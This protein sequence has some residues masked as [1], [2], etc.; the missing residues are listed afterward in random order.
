[1]TKKEYKIGNKYSTRELM[2]LAVLL[3]YESIPEHADR[4][5][6][7]VGAV[8]AKEDGTLI[9]KAYR[10]EL[11]QGDHAEFTVLERKHRT[12]KLD[13]FIIYS[14][15]EPCAPGARSIT[16]LS[17]A[18][19]IVNARIKKVFIG[20]EDPD[21]KV[22]GNGIA[23]LNNNHIEIDFFDKDLQEKTLIANEPFLK[24]AAD[25]A[26]TAEQ[27]ELEPAFTELDKILENF[28]VKDFS[29][30]AL[31]KFREKLQISYPIESMDFKSI[32]RK[33][34]FIRVE[35]KNKT[36]YPTGLGILLFGKTPQVP[37]PQSLVKFTIKT[38]NENKPKIL[39]FDGPLVLIPEKIESYLEINFPKAIDRSTI[40]RKEIKEVYFEVLREVIINAIVHRDYRIEEANINVKIDDE[41]I[42]VQSPGKPLVAI[43]KMKNYSAPTFSVNPKIANVFYQMKFIEKRNMGMEELHEFAEIMGVNKP[44]IE[45]D[46][47]Y[48]KVTLWKKA[49]S[50]IEVTT[51]MIIEFIK[52]NGNVSTGNFAQRFGGSTKTASRVLNSL[53][54][55]GILNREGEKKGTRYFLKK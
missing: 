24:E 53:V 29:N 14:T 30:D 11:R 25:R 47:P 8:L 41:K 16:K 33:W 42:E 51:E 5:D 2:E 18:E 27:E 46:E 17:C 48:L 1:M 20:L 19:R 7:K 31:E 39:D 40:T 52:T 50:K 26:K 54:D 32:L 55:K 23:F 36:A 37:F 45:Y 35:N 3:M 43:E 15:L 34:N 13:G 12:D 38:Q 28:D 9:N 10:G 4:F 49:E 22:K 44:I 6:P 21:P